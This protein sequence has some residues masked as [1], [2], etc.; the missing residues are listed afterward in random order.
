MLLD[1]IRDLL[2]EYIRLV[3]PYLDPDQDVLPQ[4]YRILERI[5]ARDEEGARQAMRQHLDQMR[6]NHEKYA[7]MSGKA[8]NSLE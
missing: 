3:T 7:R 8:E 1:S 6:K 4:H 2:Q 5:E